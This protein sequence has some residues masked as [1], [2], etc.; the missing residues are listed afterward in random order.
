MQ[1]AGA[2]PGLDRSGWRRGQPCPAGRQDILWLGLLLPTGA[3]SLRLGLPSV[4]LWIHPGDV[5]L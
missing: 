1:G 3:L 5:H 2:M 4:C